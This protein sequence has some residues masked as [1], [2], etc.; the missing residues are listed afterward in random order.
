LRQNAKMH[1]H[2]AHAA[3]GNRKARGIDRAR[4]AQFAAK[5]DLAAPFSAA[6]ECL[7]AALALRAALDIGEGRPKGAQC[8]QLFLKQRGIIGLCRQRARHVIQ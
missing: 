8:R 6:A 3:L 7:I 1:E 5:R 4:A 2:I